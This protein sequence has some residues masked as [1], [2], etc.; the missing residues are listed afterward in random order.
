[1]ITKFLSKLDRQFTTFSFGFDEEKYDEVVDI[2]TKLPKNVELIPAYF[3]KEQLIAT[4][5]D[6]LYYFETPLGGLGT[7]SSYNMNKIVKE[8]NFKVI[9][10]GEGCDEVFA[11]YRYYFDSRIADIMRK[12]ETLANQEFISYLKSHPEEDRSLA[13][14][15]KN[16]EKQWTQ[17]FVSAPDNSKPNS[18]HLGECYFDY[19]E[20][21][22]SFVSPFGDNLRVPPL[23]IFNIKSFQNYSISKTG[24]QWHQ[25]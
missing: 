22:K 4:L 17:L 23:L 6:A 19:N 10:C 2:R 13:E 5:S 12:N 15:V 24:P 18:S 16:G 7:L 1:M 14:I 21:E 9:L 8:N 20:S 25:S 11:G 3:R